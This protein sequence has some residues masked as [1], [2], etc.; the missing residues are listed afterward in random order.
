[1]NDTII[2]VENLSKR[3]GNKAESRNGKEAQLE[4]QLADQREATKWQIG[5]G[6]NEW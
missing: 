2:T 4:E 6:Q 1:M 5:K 3:I